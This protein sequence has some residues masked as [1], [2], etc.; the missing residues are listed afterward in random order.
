MPEDVRARAFEPFFTTKAPGAGSGL[1][2]SQAFGVA[3]QS[4]GTVAI[5]S[6]PGRGTSVRLLLPLAPRGDAL[7][8]TP[9]AVARPAAHARRILLVD[10]DLKVLAVVEELLRSMGH[11]VT[12]A[13]SGAEALA[14]L[15]RGLEIDL[16]ISDVM[17]PEMQGTELALLVRRRL[18]SL[19]VLF[20]SGFA[21]PAL[22]A[23]LGP[24]SQ[25]LRK[26]CRRDAIE[27]AIAGLFADAGRGE[28]GVVG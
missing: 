17:M 12:G 4:G 14:V 22:L 23:D 2:L 9:V 7:P 5:D 11:A 26:P 1:G 21:D 10:D 25:L 3:R 27:R 16:L 19:P 28:L 24:G 13:A 6:A 20:L 18:P 8:P 15:D